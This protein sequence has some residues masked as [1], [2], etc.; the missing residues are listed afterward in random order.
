MTTTGRRN[1]GWRLGAGAALWVACAQFFIAEQ[2]ARLGFVGPY[3]LRRNMISDLGALHCGAICSHWHALMNGS[4]ALQALLIAGGAIVLPFRMPG[5]VLGLLA[6]AWLVVAA[7]GLLQVARFPED[8]DIIVHTAGAGRFFIFSA[9][10]MLC[11]GAAI[12]VRERRV[13]AEAAWALAAGL[14]TGVGCYLLGARS[15]LGAWT[16]WGAV[17]RM[18]AYPLPLW[19][20]GVGVALWRGRA[21]A[22]QG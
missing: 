14:V 17:E 19:L 12:I 8:V 21:R 4:F 1:D 20:T 22:R 18:V 13:R 3:S 10:A 2:I 5:G 15:S 11:W 6:R 16:G 7:F 9:L